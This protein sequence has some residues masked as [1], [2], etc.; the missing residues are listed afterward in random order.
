ML[1]LF[2]KIF[3]HSRATNEHEI[4]AGRNVMAT[5]IVGPEVTAYKSYIFKGSR[6]H[7]KNIYIKLKNLEIEL[8]RTA[9]AVSKWV[10]KAK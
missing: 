8:S 10:K 7:I 2:S 5:S 9:I 6:V 4:S 3:E 1:N